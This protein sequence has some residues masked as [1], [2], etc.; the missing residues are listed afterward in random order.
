MK[1]LTLLSLMVAVSGFASAAPDIQHG[2][3]VAKTVCAACHGADGN[4]AIAM[5]PRLASQQFSYI[6]EQTKNIRDGKRTNGSSVTMRALVSG[7]SDTDIS[8]VAFYFSKQYPKSD[9]ANPKD[10][11]DLGTKIFRGGLADKHVPACMSCH[12]PT[13]AGMP[14]G[15]VAKDGIIAYPRLSGQHKSYVA[16]QLKAYRNGQR[17]HSVMSDIAQRLSDEEIDAV[18]NFIQGLH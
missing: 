13:G 8:D 12:G 14:A 1:R 16:D 9:E 4:S 17:P 10:N 2:E 3:Q 5:Y 7:L 18:A 6:V 15:S 11:L